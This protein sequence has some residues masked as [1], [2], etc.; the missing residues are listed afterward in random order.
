MQTEDIQ[1]ASRSRSGWEAVDLGFSMVR[2]WWKPLYGA[3]IVL[4]WPVAL[5]LQLVLI[6]HLW[7]VPLVLLWLKPLFDR[8]AMYVLSEALFGKAP[9][10]R[11]TILAAPGLLRTG[12]I[13]SLTWLRFTPLRSFSMPVLQLEGARG[14]RRRDRTRLLIGRESH[15]GMSHLLACFHFEVLLYL[16]SFYLLWSFIPREVD[17]D[18]TTFLFDIESPG[19]QIL[20]NTIYILSVTLVEPFY[21]AGGFG[22]YINRRMY[23]EGWDIEL[24]FRRLA[25]RVEAERSRA[26]GVATTLVFFLVLGAAAFP[27]NAVA[28]ETVPARIAC[29]A[30]RPQDASDCIA[31]ILE[32][33]EFDTTEEETFWRRVGGPEEEENPEPVS[34]G[35]LDGLFELFGSVLSAVFK[36]IAWIAIFT[37]VAIL[38]YLVSRYSARSGVEDP[39]SMDEPEFR[40][41]LDLRPE[42]LP[43]DILAAARAAYQAGDPAGALSLLY[44]GALIYLTR[45]RGLDLPASATEGECTRLA[46]HRLDAGLARDF[47]DLTLAWQFCAYGSK[48]PGF[49]AFAELCERW[50]PYLQAA[51]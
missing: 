15:I 34:P 42:S 39:E 32:Q 9:S 41:G 23:L 27:K 12:V 7:V 5:L 10:L 16:G 26:P 36:S 35:A 43:D 50:R 30:A 20:S 45:D 24:A 13:A 14:E 6:D 11:E 21:V 37:G 2:T 4:V 40:F 3:W 17:I 51:A 8:V 31:R 1:V 47:G 28:D 33:P 44:R 22:L 38:G 29:P 18:F 48:E 19:Q 25:N 49:E 46:S